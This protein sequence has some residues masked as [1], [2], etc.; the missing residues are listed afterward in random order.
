[1]KTKLEIMKTKTTEIMKTKINQLV[2]VALFAFIML[3]GNV[4]AKG[5]EINTSNYENIVEPALELEDWMVNENYW[6]TAEN[7]I[8]LIGIADKNLTLESWMTDVKTWITDSIAYLK[9]ETETE[10]FLESWMTNE[11]VWNK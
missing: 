11:S 7:A 8:Y 1:M 5:T 4:S 3:A 2:V 9:T 10:L 6:N